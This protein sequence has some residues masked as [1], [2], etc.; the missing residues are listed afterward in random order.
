MY[1]CANYALLCLCAS[2][3]SEDKAYADRKPSGLL[4]VCMYVCVYIYI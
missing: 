3:G 2:S 4:D 1:A